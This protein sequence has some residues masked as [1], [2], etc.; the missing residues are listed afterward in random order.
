MTPAGGPTA[1]ARKRQ[2]PLPLSGGLSG[3]GVRAGPGNLMS[4]RCFLRCCLRSQEV[5]WVLGRW[6]GFQ[7]EEGW[8]GGRGVGR[9]ALGGLVSFSVI[10]PRTAVE[11][12]GKLCQ[13]GMDAKWDSQG[14]INSDFQGQRQTGVSPRP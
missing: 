2:F 3:L 9:G 11:S 14:D 7:M 5:P 12:T 4:S 8:G 1:V 13:A 6:E 10:Q